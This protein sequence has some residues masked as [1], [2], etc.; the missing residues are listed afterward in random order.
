[1]VS[2][3]RKE[4]VADGAPPA[5]NERFRERHPAVGREIRVEPTVMLAM[6]ALAAVAGVAL[7]LTKEDADRHLI[8]APVLFAG[9]TIAMTSWDDL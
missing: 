4:R 8:A 9:L 7:F 6:L 1:M 5:L 2:I 3:W